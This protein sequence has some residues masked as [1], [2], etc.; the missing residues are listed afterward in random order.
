VNL[1]APLP[2]EE[3]TLPPGPGEAALAMH[4]Q[5]VANDPEVAAEARQ[6]LQTQ[7]KMLEV[8]MENLHEQRIITL[9]HLKR[10]ELSDRLKLFIQVLTII[11]GALALMIVAGA[12]W[13]AS[14][15][16]ALIIEPISGPPEL[17]ANGMTPTATAAQLLDKLR[18]MQAKT[19]SARAANTFKSNWSDDIKVE[20]PETG[21]SI[22]EL[23]RLMRRWLGDDDY[24]S[25]EVHREGKALILTARVGDRPGQA[26][27]SDEGSLDAAMQKAAEAIYASTQPYRYSVYL[28][29][30]D[31][32]EE[33]KAVLSELAESGP[34]KE[35]PWAYIGL[36]GLIGAEGDFRRGAALLRKGLDL[37]PNLAAG[38]SVL[39]G[40]EQTLGRDE[41]A[42]QAAVRTV[43]TLRRTDRGGVTK[44]AADQRMIDAR[45]A[46]AELKGDFGQAARIRNTAGRLDSYQSFTESG[47]ALEA[48]NR[49]YAHEPLRPE[50]VQL[51]ADDVETPLLR[52]Q[53]LAAVA[54][55]TDRWG[56]LAEELS[57]IEQAAAD[58]EG[59]DWRQQAWPVQVWPWRALAL[60]RTGRY[61]E[62]QGLI[63][64]T[65]L[66]CYL[67]LR[68]RGEIA[69]LS[70]DRTGRDAWYGRAT[71]AAPSL[72]FA[73]GEWGR[74]LARSGEHAEAERKFRQARRLGPRWPEPLVWWAWS[75]QAQG[76]KSDAELRFAAAREIAP[77]WRFSG[78][79]PG[80]GGR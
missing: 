27:R 8:Q 9:N 6:Y 63:A 79:P 39:S 15:S 20:I 55:V 72:P 7:S 76:R 64:Q 78:R 53:L 46:V 68:V 21:I 57:A 40:T 14:R 26:F 61:R 4:L 41:Q 73:W 62:A 12:L 34:A 2:M 71:K 1:T 59:A 23:F 3:L 11:G 29:Q 42:Y 80:F 51:P 70:N 32:S 17:A 19:D 28:S 44:V 33:A 54:Y 25:G 74:A 47:S 35:R 48:L 36:G 49:I 60:A 58:D 45:A 43:E 24:I 5:G 75:L 30:N 31:R 65:P 56:G 69:A 18:A 38:W 10:M 16:N 22:G 66:D 13:D 67:C 77:P 37:D 50:V 52:A